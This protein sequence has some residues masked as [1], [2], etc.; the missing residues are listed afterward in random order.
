[1]TGKIDL[2]MHS[3]CSDGTDSPEELAGKVQEAGIVFFALTDH[4][5]VAGVPRMQK[6]AKEKGIT[7]V[8]GVEFSCL[9]DGKDAD[10]DCHIL[11]L[12]IDVT[13]ESIQQ[14]V[15]KNQENRQKKLYEI[16]DYLES[17]SIRLEPEVIAELSKIHN[18]GK[19]A[20]A[21]AAVD[22]GYMM[23]QA[24][25][26]IREEYALPQQAEIRSRAKDLLFRNYLNDFSSLLHISA[27]EAI[28]GIRKAGGVAVWAHP[29]GDKKD[30]ATHDCGLKF[31]T[32][33]ES[34][35][36]FGIQGLECCYSR[37]NEEE[38]AFLLQ[39]ARRH[40]LLISGGSDY[41]GKNKDTKLAQTGRDIAHQEEITVHKIWA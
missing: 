12:G 13:H 8:S 40:H 4:D 28:E 36:G 30:T 20:V 34:L 11:G 27:K 15:Q 16:L 7:C 41:H 29:I 6:L 23:E 21:N 25:K 39:T 3:T 9:I 33:L 31:S 18:V 22:A 19:P 32:Q 5:T 10:S 14:L 38:I 17:F 35:M 2:H 37:Y 1:M 24:E 26:E